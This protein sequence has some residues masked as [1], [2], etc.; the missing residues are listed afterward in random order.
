MAGRI[1]VWLRAMRA[2]SFTATFVPVTLAAVIAYRSGAEVNWWL[3]PLVLLGGLSINAASDLTNE[4][5][6]FKLGVD[7][8]GVT[9]SSGVL[10]E[11]SLKP[12][13]VL[14]A[15]IS[16]YL[17]A[18]FLAI[19]FVW[20]WG[21]WMAV[22]I[23]AGLI[24]G[25]G[26]T[27]GKHGY[28]YFALGEPMCFIFYGPM[29]AI[30]GYMALTGKYGNAAALASIPVGF[31]VAAILNVNNF[32]DIE[33]DRRSKIWTIPLMLGKANARLLY[34]S[35]VLAAYV[36]ISLLSFFKVVP[37]WALLTFLT[38]PMAIGLISVVYGSDTT[39]IKGL[40]IG[41][42]KLHLAFGLLLIV[43]LL[44]GK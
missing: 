23:A 34:A 1:I 6:D 25:Y 30:G 3:F 37:L 15:S 18:V 8:A 26:Y 31:L 40:D 10:I 4:Y 29:M 36:S 13:Q 9:G 22:V 32:R 39:K 19:Y 17:L 14:K 24:A 41:T 5:Y 44:I 28:K 27:A 7:R 21:L 43:S 2:F 12:S 20:L 16:F 11:G 38:L 42:A 33:D 35:M